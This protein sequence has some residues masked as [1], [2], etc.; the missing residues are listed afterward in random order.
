MH[1]ENHVKNTLTSFYK[2]LVPVSV[3]V[4]MSSY[5]F[6][7]HLWEDSSPFEVEGWDRWNQELQLKV[8]SRNR[9]IIDV[10]IRPYNRGLHME[11]FYTNSDGSKF[12][13][14]PTICLP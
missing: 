7:N 3:I 2:S 14:S 4:E 10:N 1:T 12:S 5:F 11:S 8:F 9:G 6:Y 13:T